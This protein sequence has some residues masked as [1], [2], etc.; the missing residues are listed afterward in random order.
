MD[1]DNALK[2]LSL[3]RIALGVWFLKLGL[4]HIDLAHFPQA[5]G[6]WHREMDRL[7]TL[8][9]SKHP[10]PWFVSFV[11]SQVLPHKELFVNYTSVLELAA[12]ALL[13]LGL[14]TPL[15]SLLM[16][17]YALFF[18][19]LEVHYGLGPQGLYFALAVACVAFIMARAGRV[20]GLDFIPAGIAPGLPLW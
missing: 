19:L 10:Y 16:I 13:F 14:L 18:M 5:G 11:Q 2:G 1:N 8:Y 4:A 3:L 15:I 20:W 17:P 9:L 12:G 7:F 6:H